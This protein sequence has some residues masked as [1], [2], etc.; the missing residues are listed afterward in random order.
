[1]CLPQPFSDV[2]RRPDG[3]VRQLDRIIDTFRSK[4]DIV[5]SY[6]E[7]TL[8]VPA[9]FPRD[10]F[11]ELRKLSGDT[12]AKSLLGKYPSQVTR[13]DC[14]EASADIDTALDLI[15]AGAESRAD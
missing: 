1:M 11:H 15:G 8:G 3:R 13:L 9:L 10:Y 4:G 5:A 12:G 2:H 14:P 6:Y 7:N